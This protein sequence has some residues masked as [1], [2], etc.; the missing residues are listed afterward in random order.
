MG[1][2][3]DQVDR[4]YRYHK[5]NWSY[6]SKALGKS[7]NSF[8]HTRCLVIISESEKQQQSDRERRLLSKPIKFFNEMQE[9]FSGSS[10]NGSLAMD[11]NTCMDGSDGS[12]SDEPREL[13]DLNTYTQSEDQLGEDSDTLPTPTR[14]AA[15]GN[16]SS[17]TSRGG[18]KFPRSS[19]SPTKKPKKGVLWQKLEAIPMTPDQRFL[20]GEHLS[21]KENKGK[22]GWLCNASADTLH[23]WVF[24]F[25]CEKEG[26]NL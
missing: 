13:F 11:Q 7:G 16:S 6:I 1:V 19:K 15:I 24:K 23:A 22:R 25:L 8:D 17:S 10:A 12:D 9:L 18:K 5:E 2:T 20:V 21:T 4:H 3:V 14:S 26:I